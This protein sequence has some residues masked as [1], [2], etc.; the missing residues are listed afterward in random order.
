MFD[1]KGV[2]VIDKK[3]GMDEE[4]VE[5]AAIEAGAE[6][7]VVEENHFEVYTEIS[8]F[9]AVRDALQADGYEFS[10][11]E[12]RYLPQTMAQLTDEDDIKYMSKLID[13]ME[14]NDDVQNL[15]HNWEESE[16]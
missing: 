15:Y 8:D 9:S 2:L 16:A 5:M 13:L 7:F 11:A 12:L 14:E 3:E 10:M 6:D 4:E 1:H